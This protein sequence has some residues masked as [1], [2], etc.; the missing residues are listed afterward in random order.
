MVRHCGS[1]LQINEVLKASFSMLKKGMISEWKLAVNR[2]G[3]V[4]LSISIS[5]KWWNHEIYDARNIKDR[6]REYLELAIYHNIW[7]MK[8][9]ADY[10]HAMVNTGTFRQHFRKFSIFPRKSGWLAHTVLHEKIALLVHP[11]KVLLSKNLGKCG[12]ALSFRSVNLAS[13]PRSAKVH[14]L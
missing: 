11:L 7:P 5:R 4:S 12:L 9:F 1:K 6:F 13:R 3:E 10:F 8:Y 14:E 2:S